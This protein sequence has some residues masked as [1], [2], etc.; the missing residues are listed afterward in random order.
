MIESTLNG[1]IIERTTSAFVEADS[2][3]IFP[4][5]D[6]RTHLYLISANP[7]TE[8]QTIYAVNHYFKVLADKDK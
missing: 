4:K 8:E 3:V 1:I 5:N 6:T 7:L 2:V